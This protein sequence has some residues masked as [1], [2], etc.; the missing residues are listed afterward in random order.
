MIY[1]YRKKLLLLQLYKS[2]RDYS[3][4]A[5]CETI[6]CTIDYLETL[7]TELIKEGKIEYNDSYL[8]SVTNQGLKDISPWLS[9]EKFQLY[10]YVC[11]SDK[12][13]INA[14]YLPEKNP[15]M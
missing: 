9:D 7:I 12:I 11:M 14:P 15:Q 1:D 5:C 13:E 4:Q 10:R 8:L 6:G 3:L 2:Q